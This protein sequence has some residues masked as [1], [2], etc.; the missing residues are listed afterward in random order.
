VARARA[1]VRMGWHHETPSWL[2][3]RTGGGWARRGAR[4]LSQPLSQCKHVLIE[5]RSSGYNS[6]ADVAAQPPLSFSLPS[7]SYALLPV[8]TSRA[9]PPLRTLLALLVLFL[10]AGAARL[11][12]LSSIARSFD[13]AL[14]V[15]RRTAISR[16]PAGFWI[17]E[18]SWG[19]FWGLFMMSR[20]ADNW[21]RH[22][23]SR[24]PCKEILCNLR[25]VLSL[26]VYDTERKRIMYS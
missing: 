19:H 8:P 10:N 26:Y 22:V 3:P 6:F 1:R 2:E 17:G 7:S 15:P 25:F 4:G 11:W 14:G 12:F 18:E 16:H 21:K 20:N 23:V 13:H 9:E 24:V 5:I